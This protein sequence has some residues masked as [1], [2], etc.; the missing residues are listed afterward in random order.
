MWFQKIVSLE[1][2][3]TRLL[4]VP[5]VLRALLTSISPLPHKGRAHRVHRAA[6][7]EVSQEP[8][9]YRNASVARGEWLTIR[10]TAFAKPGHTLMARGALCA[11]QGNTAL[12][13]MLL[14]ARNAL[15]VRQ[16]R[17]PAATLNLIAFAKAALLRRV[18]LQLQLMALISFSV[19]AQWA[20]L[21]QLMVLTVRTALKTIS[22]P[23]KIRKPARVVQAVK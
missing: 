11:R 6:L 9:L 13:T 21:L 18:A 5:L 17:Q 19:F 20:R 2:S 14:R 1:P 12:S 4:A 8:P 10:A 3:A 16:Q 15:V 23:S 7:P 22:T